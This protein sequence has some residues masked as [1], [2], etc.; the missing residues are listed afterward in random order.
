MS[1]VCGVDM[2]EVER[3]EGAVQR[4]GSR[5]LRRVF[6]EREQQACGGRCSSLAARFAAKEAVAKALGT[7][8]G[9]VGWLEIEVLPG[10]D[11]QPLLH[12]HGAAARRAAQLGLDEWSLSLSHTREHAVALAVASGQKNFLE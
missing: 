5:F 7:G 1:L 9:P 4:S 8:I 6:T 2:I 10:P 3:V 12:L 11:G